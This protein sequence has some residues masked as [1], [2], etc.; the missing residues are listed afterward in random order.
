MLI[1]PA[2]FSQSEMVNH[3]YWKF[4]QPT[5][6]FILQPK[7]DFLNQ[8]PVKEPERKDFIQTVLPFESLTFGCRINTN[9]AFSLIHCFDKRSLKTRWLKE[10]TR[11]NNVS[12]FALRLFKCQMYGARCQCTRT[13]PVY[14]VCFFYS[15]ELQP[16]IRSAQ[17]M[18]ANLCLYSQLQCFLLNKNLKSHDKSVKIMACKPDVNSHMKCIHNPGIRGDI[19]V[20]F[21][22]WSDKPLMVRSHRM[23]ESL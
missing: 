6:F 9:A 5:L 21:S 16:T 23:S 12:L 2:F 18:C 1:R 17:W 8:I 3:I 13:L 15:A 11:N 7:L 19:G 22:R 20:L 10:P 4:T 14:F